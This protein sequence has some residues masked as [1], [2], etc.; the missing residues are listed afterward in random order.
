MVIFKNKFD[1]V[2]VIPRID[3][4][5]TARLVSANSGFQSWPFNLIVKKQIIF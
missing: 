4:V 5:G 2:A 3:I 1:K